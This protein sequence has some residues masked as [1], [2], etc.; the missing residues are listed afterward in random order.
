MPDALPAVTEPLFSNAGFRPPNFSTVVPGRGYSS[1]STR[2]GSPFF[3]GI[4]TGTIS[5]LN[6]PLC[7]RGGGAALALR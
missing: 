2:T 4:S 1:V 6:A 7:D 3:C 5:A